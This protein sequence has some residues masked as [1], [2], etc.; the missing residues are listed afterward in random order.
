M[1]NSPDQDDDANI[2]NIDQLL[3]SNVYGPEQ[4]KK[5]KLAFNK[6]LQKFQK[7]F[8][9]LKDCIKL[10]KHKN[11]KLII[12]LNKNN[13]HHNT[14]EKIFSEC[15]DETKRDILSRKLKESNKY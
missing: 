6:L 8:F 4:L 12:E 13:N 1:A 11:S 3:N 9:K 15:V 7:I 5:V 14:L 10:A 2:E